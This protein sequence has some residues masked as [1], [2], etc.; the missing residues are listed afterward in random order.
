[1]KTKKIISWLVV[2]CLM[3][4]LFAV[5][6]Y[7]TEQQFDISANGDGSIMATFNSETGVLDIT[8][9][10]KTKHYTDSPFAGLLSSIKTINVGEGI[11]LLGSNLFYI[12][13]YSGDSIKNVESVSLP[14]TL[15]EI[16]TQAFRL[17]GYNSFLE[18]LTLPTNLKY[19]QDY[20]FYDSSISTIVN[21]SEESQ[22]I[23]S[24]AFS[25]VG[26]PTNS[27]VVKLYSTNTGMLDYIENEINDKVKEVIYLDES[28]SNL[29]TFDFSENGDG[30]I[31]GTYNPDTKTL[32]IEGTGEMKRYTTGTSIVS[33]LQ[34]VEVINIHEGITDVNNCFG[35]DGTNYFK[36]LKELNLP[37]TLKYIGQYAFYNVGWTVDEIVFPMENMHFDRNSVTGAFTSITFLSKNASI[38]GAG[39]MS[40]KSG[41]KVYL[42]KSATN[43]PLGIGPTYVYFDDMANSGTLDNGITWSYDSSTGTLTFDGEGE[44]PTYSTDAETPWYG[45]GIA[46]N[47]SSYVFGSGITGI[48]SA[49]AGMGGA[50]KNYG[51]GTTIYAPGSLSNAI[52]SALPNATIE[53]I[54]SLDSTGGDNSND[55][56]ETGIWVYVDNEEVEFPDVKPRVNFGVVYA[57]LRFINEDL[58]AD[59]Y[60]NQSE[61][62][63][64]I[65]KT[66]NGKT[67]SIVLKPNSSS[68]WVNGQEYTEDELGLGATVL[69]E[70]GRLLLPGRA[71]VKAW[72][73]VQFRA[74]YT[75]TSYR[76][77]YYI[78]ETTDEPVD[79]KIETED[80]TPELTENDKLITEDNQTDVLSGYGD[81]KILVNAEST[82]F[83]VSTPVLIPVSV[84]KMGEVT[85]PTDLYI[86]NKCAWGPIVV[87]EIEFIKA[88]GWE[89]KEFDTYDFKNALADSKYIGLEINSVSV[90]ADGSVD[91]NDSLSST[92]LYQS[93]KQITFDAKIPAQRTALKEICAGIIFTVDFDKYGE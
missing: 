81:T 87:E 90:N 91:M 30:S 51:S 11:T 26:I 9:S 76:D 59:V 42:W 46:Y 58:G 88:N 62:Y 40:L 35:Y 63:A 29:V 27:L 37:T 18:E 53:D 60:W 36:N 71:I 19:I 66:E 86:E 61:H 4:S 32:D 22:S 50:S 64:T 39:C 47:P 38:P 41:G 56:T 54:G 49:F 7:A 5:P 20:A 34:D 85:I 15:T 82:F 80:S 21:L 33:Q 23:K 93:K 83:Y 12:Q 70:N 79:E 48:G 73:T 28:Q 31:I 69:L 84:N 24:N 13:S 45:T 77:Y 43:R 14:S 8:G 72:E 78:N 57:P 92:I 25:S 74:V 2:M 68:M 16:S 89:L 3:L 75:A 10:G 55:T 1:M 67:V 52:S 17:L 65:V 44:I 6:T